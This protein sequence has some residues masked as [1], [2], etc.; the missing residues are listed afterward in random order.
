MWQQSN[1]RCKVRRGASSVLACMPHSWSGAVY[2]SRRLTSTVQSGLCS[3][4][5]AL[6]RC[7]VVL[8][9]LLSLLCVRTARQVLLRKVCMQSRCA[10]RSKNREVPADSHIPAQAVLPILQLGPPPLPSSLYS[11]LGHCQLAGLVACET[12]STSTIKRCG[13]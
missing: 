1:T 4:R 7:F 11:R 6:Q 9:S 8:L 10:Q 2:C 13:A 5:G 12:A 3:V